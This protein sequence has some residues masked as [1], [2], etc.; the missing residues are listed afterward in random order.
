MKRP[1]P[2][3]KGSGQPPIDGDTIVDGEAS[4]LECGS[5]VSGRVDYWR[6]HCGAGDDAVQRAEAY[7][8]TFVF[9]EALES[10]KDT[11]EW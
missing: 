1:T 10:G 5:L 11:T 7:Y 8:T 6:S 9:R 3:R 4:V 2:E